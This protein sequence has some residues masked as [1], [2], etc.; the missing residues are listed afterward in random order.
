MTSSIGGIEREAPELVAL[1]DVLLADRARQCVADIFAED[2]QV[3]GASGVIAEGFEDCF[4]IADGHALAEEVL[5]HL[6]QFARFDLRGNDF[7][8]QGGDAVLEIVERF[9][10][11]W[12]VSNS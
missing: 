5:H 8:D 3:L 12:R 9:F 6:L 11:A 4:Q 7:F 1:V 10:T 2:F